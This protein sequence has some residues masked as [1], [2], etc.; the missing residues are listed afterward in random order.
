MCVG[1][2]VCVE[3]HEYVK[4]SMGMCGG[5]WVCIEEHGYV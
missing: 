5:A 3:K 4:R 2:W 1:A